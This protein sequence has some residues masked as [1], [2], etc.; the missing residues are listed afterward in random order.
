MP[1][2]IPVA[3]A[4]GMLLST[5]L[6]PGAEG[7]TAAEIKS[8]EAAPP[9]SSLSAAIITVEG[10]S[11]GALLDIG[12]EPRHG[13]A[14]YRAHLL[15]GSR[16]VSVIIDPAL[17]SLGPWAAV[18]QDVAPELKPEETA[19]RMLEIG[20]LGFLEAVALAEQETGGKPIDARLTLEKG[21]PAYEIGVVDGGRLKTVLIDPNTAGM[22]S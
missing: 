5:S 6:A 3:V 15:D 2:A 12:Y 8:F 10:S 20:D 19:E 16:L 22:A 9:D 7:E 18:E 13:R 4:I 14:S 21:R 1:G 17:D 11:D